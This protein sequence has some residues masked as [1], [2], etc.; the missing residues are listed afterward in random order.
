MT[1]EQLDRYAKM[2][3][4]LIELRVENKSLAIQANDLEREIRI[5]CQHSGQLQTRLDAIEQ[6]RRRCAMLRVE[7]T[8]HGLKRV[9]AHGK[10]END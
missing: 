7:P 2:A 3:A 1:N 10:E 4:E 8:S 5:L 9:L 6:Y